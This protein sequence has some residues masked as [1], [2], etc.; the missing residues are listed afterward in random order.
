MQCDRKRTSR[1]EEVVDMDVLIPLTNRAMKSRKDTTYNVMIV[2]HHDIYRFGLRNIL[3]DIDGFSMVAD[4]S[5][6]KDAV[7]AMEL[8]PVDLILMDLYLPDLYGIDALQQLRKATAAPQIIIVAETLNDDVLLESLLAGASGFLTKDSPASA[9]ITALQG[10]RRGELAMVPIVATRAIRL[11]VQAYGEMKAE[12]ARSLQNESG[13]LPV[14]ETLYVMANAPNGSSLPLL[15]PQE[16]RVFRLLRQGRSNKQIAAH[17]SISPYTVGKHVQNI[18]RKLGVAN[19]TQ[20]ASYPL[21]EGVQM[22][23]GEASHT[24]TISP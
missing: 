2:D 6:Y 9:I 15:T 22:R 3:N 17:L 20:A 13:A 19:R 7:A 21:F 8:M 1:F 10:F 12:L 11:L 4:A 16:E 18:L 5:S 14:P 23:G 24:W